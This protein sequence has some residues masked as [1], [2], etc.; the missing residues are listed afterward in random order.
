MILGFV[1]AVTFLAPVIVSVL[2]GKLI[3]A[4][5]NPELAEHKVWPLVVGV[6]LFAILAAIPFL[7]G[8][9][10]FVMALLGLGALWLYGRDLLKNGRAVEQA[11]G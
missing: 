2:V 3:L 1:L 4:K 8:L 9:F 11:A 6:V 5:I 10:S 7:G